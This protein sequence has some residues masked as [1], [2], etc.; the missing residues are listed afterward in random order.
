MSYAHFF[1]FRKKNNRQIARQNIKND[2]LEN[3]LRSLS[4]NK[5]TN[6]NN[7]Y[8]KLYLLEIA[9]IPLLSKEKEKEYA[10][11]IAQGDKNA[12][13][14]MIKANLRL[15]VN[16]AKRYL[17]CGL[18]FLD[19]IQEG[20]I[21]LIRAVEKFDLKHNCKFSTYAIWWIRQGITRSLADKSRTI[22]I[23][24]HTMESVKALVESHQKFLQENHREPEMAE[25][26]E[27]MG[28]SVQKA[29]ELSNLIKNP[30]SVEQPS[31]EYTD[32]NLFDY[33][34]DK[35]YIPALDRLINDNLK[36]EIQN[37]LNKLSKREKNVIEMRF[38]LGLNGAKTLEEVGSRLNLSRERVRQI[39]HQAMI[40]LKQPSRLKRLNDFI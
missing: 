4:E 7:Y 24:V 18:S 19:L 23:P 39:Q 33:L 14:E 32:C 35:R 29:N 40:K 28:L 36:E 17:N 20:N 5:C 31:T 38:G 13:Y 25:L 9:K 21:G 26:A 1:K 10:L 37:L 11:K 6:E 2:D 16:I 3:G 12:K 22:R 30:I 27:S 8:V 15:V 34:E